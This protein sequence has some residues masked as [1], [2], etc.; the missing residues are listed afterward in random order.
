[1][2][3]NNKRKKSTTVAILLGLLAVIISVFTCS[4]TIIL[5]N[6]DFD[7][8]RDFYGPPQEIEPWNPD[9]ERNP[10]MMP[11]DP[12]MNNG[13]EILPFVPDLE[14][15]VMLIPVEPELETIP[16]WTPDMGPVNPSW[17]D[18]CL[19]ESECVQPIGN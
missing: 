14:N 1:M 10:E 4:M 2:S 16:G 11:I 7:R 18:I 13:F 12:D 8:N 17:F 6:L 15:D 9:M 19:P 3:T 5:P